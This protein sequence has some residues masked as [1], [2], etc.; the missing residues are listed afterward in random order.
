MTLNV[1]CAISTPNI[2][3]GYM[4]LGIR[5]TGFKHLDVFDSDGKDEDGLNSDVRKAVERVKLEYTF[6]R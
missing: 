6:R 1:S 3:G 2:F 5:D 4:E